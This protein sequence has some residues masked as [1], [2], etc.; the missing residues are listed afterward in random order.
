MVARW[1]H[2]PKKA[3]RVCQVL[4]S[5]IFK[6]RIYLWAHDPEIAFIIP[7][8]LKRRDILD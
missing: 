4:F 7:R 2:D 1:A 3:V 5:I 8:Y 6:C